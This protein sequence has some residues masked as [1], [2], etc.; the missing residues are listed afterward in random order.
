MYLKFLEFKNS[1]EVKLD[2]GITL[3]K[4]LGIADSG[5]ASSGIRTPSKSF[6]AVCIPAYNEERYIAKVIIGAKRNADIVIVCDDGSND[7]TAEIA[8]GLGAYVIRHDRNLGKGSALKSL[9]EKA[10]ELGAEVVVTLDGDGQHDPEEIP[11]IVE[12]ILKAQADIVNGSRAGNQENIPRYRRFGNR[13][14]NYLTVKASHRSLEDSQSGYRAY[15]KRA[16]ETLEVTEQGIG[17]DSQ[18]VIDAQRKGL[19]IVEIPISVKYD[20]HS[21]TYNP[22]SHA[23]SVVVAVVR[24]LTERSPLLYLGVP[25]VMFCFVGISLATYLLK[26][27]SE[28]RSV[29]I[30]FT[31]VSLTSIIIGSMLIIAAMILFAI[32]NLVMRL[33]KQ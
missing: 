22:I 27:Y 13:I 8:S 31:L 26:I 7:V 1:D 6:I 11:L 15:S 2:T 24:T 3:A 25:G 9:F 32:A 30:F 29:S 33:K 20:E 12:P 14:L 23:L 16:L 19:K 17:V 28:N 5:I 21:S 10:K 18:L 4:G